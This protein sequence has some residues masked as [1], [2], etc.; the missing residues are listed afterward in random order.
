MN[1][2][3][4]QLLVAIASLGVFASS[5]LGQGYP[6]KPVRIFVGYPPGG[7]PDFIARTIGQALSQTFGQQFVVENKPSAGGIVA[8]ES[9]AKA[10]PDGHTLLSG[11]TGQIEAVSYIFKSLPFDPYKDL[12]PISL[13]GIS[14]GIFV[15]SS[16]SQIGTIKDLIREAKANPGKL[17][18]GS[19]GVGSIH[20][21]L[22]EA[23]SA[24][25]GVKLTHIPF[26]G[27][28]LALPALLAGEVQVMMASL[29]VV[30]AQRQ[31][32]TI[33]LLGVTSAER[34]PFLPDVPAIADDLK[35]FDFA[36]ETGIFAPAGLPADVLAKISK[37]MKAAIETPEMQDRYKKLG[38]ILV[39]TTPEAYRERI[40]RNMKKYEQ[41][42]RTANIQAN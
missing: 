26:K 18:Y 27:A 32:G 23:F 10:A 25:A 22:W 30:N 20:H 42:I 3:L 14:P 19:S 28:S 13:V 34:F 4:K 11:E 16:K 36:S 8:T 5:S 41:V 24:A 29:G 31:A 39:W 33:N 2:L 1:V 17:N 21:I 35:G 15:S 38:L 12:T 6:I 7:V 9:V 37:A 40:R